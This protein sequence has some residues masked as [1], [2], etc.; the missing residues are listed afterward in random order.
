VFAAYRWN[1]PSGKA[2]P[3]EDALSAVIRETYEETGVHLAPGD[4]R[5]VGVVYARGRDGQSRAGFPFAAD[6]DPQ[7]HAEAVNT[8]PH[9]CSALQW[10]PL[11]APPA[12][13]EAYNAS[14]IAL[15]MAGNMFAY[16]GWS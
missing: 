2:E 7:R 4:L 5:P 11:K 10:F 16:H 9:K 12:L 3:D 1:L 15:Y 14:V 13:L 8:E 6:H